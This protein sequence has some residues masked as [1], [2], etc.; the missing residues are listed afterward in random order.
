MV[1]KTAKT[2]ND[3]APARTTE[4]G[5]GASSPTAR[6][7]GFSSSSTPKDKGAVA[8]E[9]KRIFEEALSAKIAERRANEVITLRSIT[10]R[11]AVDR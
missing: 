7:S 9:M 5:Q 10:H 6:T 2:A 4:S 8:E 11:S 3:K 1:K